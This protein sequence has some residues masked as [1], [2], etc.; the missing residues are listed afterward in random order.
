MLCCQVFMLQFSI[1]KVTIKLHFS[2]LYSLYFFGVRF[3][4]HFVPQDR[5]FNARP[6]TW[7]WTSPRSS[8]FWREP[9]RGFSAADSAVATFSERRLHNLTPP[10]QATPTSQQPPSLSNP[11][12]IFVPMPTLKQLPPTSNPSACGQSEH[13][14]RKNPI[15]QIGP[16]T[17]KNCRN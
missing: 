12:G 10:P 7:C 8:P 15:L 4:V 11:L 14:T 13:R 6:T 2:S 17:S 16:S 1:F 5:A 3:R 9:S